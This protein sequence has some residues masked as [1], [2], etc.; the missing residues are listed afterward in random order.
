[1]HPTAATLAPESAAASSSSIDSCLAAWMK[2]QVLTRTTSASSPSPRRVQPPA[3]SRAASSSE[4]TSLRA[5]PSVTRLTVRELGT[6]RAYVSSVR[7]GATAPGQPGGSGASLPP[8][9][10]AARGRCLSDIRRYGVGVATAAAATGAPPV[11]ATCGVLAGLTYTVTG[12]TDLGVSFL[13]STVS[14]TPDGLPIRTVTRCLSD[15]VIDLPAW[16]TPLYNCLPLLPEMPTQQSRMAVSLITASPAG[17]AGL[18]VA[19]WVGL[20]D[21][22]AVTVGLTCAACRGGVFAGLSAT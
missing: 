13:P 3:A 17:Y 5:Q 14:L 22:V 11:V 12:F 7:R 9:S 21:G 2:P 20:G 15:Q 4:S 8:G 16:T 18:S 10:L 1:M 6:R 19:F